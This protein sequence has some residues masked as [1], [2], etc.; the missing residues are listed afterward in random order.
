MKTENGSIVTKALKDITHLRVST[1][2]SAFMA[3]KSVE[4]ESYF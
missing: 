3:S 1:S 2:M 4:L